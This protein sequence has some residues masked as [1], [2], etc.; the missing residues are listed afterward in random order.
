[1]HVEYASK[2]CSPDQALE[3]LRNGD[4][5]IVPTGAAR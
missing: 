2:R 4:T 3:L 5:I 1:M